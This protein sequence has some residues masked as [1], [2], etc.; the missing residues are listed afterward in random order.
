M[1]PS[2]RLMADDSGEQVSSEAS[3][4]FPRE[5]AHVLSVEDK[6]TKKKRYYAERDATKVYL[7]DQHARWRTLREQMALKTDKE[8]ATILLDCYLSPKERN[9]S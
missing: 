9:F 7:F 8:L 5:Q 3:S 4:S 1:R 2:A 6:A